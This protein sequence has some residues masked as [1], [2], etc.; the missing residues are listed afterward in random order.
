MLIHVEINCTSQ[1][2]IWYKLEEI[3]I[4][5][6]MKKAL[7]KAREDLISLEQAIN[8]PGLGVDINVQITR[9]SRQSGY[10][11]DVCRKCVTVWV[12]PLVSR[13]IRRSHVMK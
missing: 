2:I 1:S 6:K 11:L 3:N 9:S 8:L 7:S 10:S 12:H 4:A 13:L 5:P